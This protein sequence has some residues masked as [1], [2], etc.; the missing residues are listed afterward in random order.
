MSHWL[1]LFDPDDG[2]PYGQVCHCELG[3]D[4]DGNGE[5]DD[6]LPRVVDGGGDD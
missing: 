6:N 5:L 1:T 2:Q 3:A 4:H